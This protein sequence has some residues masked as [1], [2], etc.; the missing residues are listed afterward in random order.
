MS[1]LI[2]LMAAIFFAALCRF[3]YVLAK[4]EA[5]RMWGEGIDLSPRALLFPAGL[6]LLTIGSVFCVAT[7]VWITTVLATYIIV[8]I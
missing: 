8:G 7:L 6:M 5:V 2:G 4:N 3:G 1:L